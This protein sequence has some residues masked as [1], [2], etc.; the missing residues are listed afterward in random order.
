[1]AN[2]TTCVL[3]MEGVDVGGG[4]LEVG[5]EG[6]VTPVGPQGGL[7]TDE[8]GAAH[9]EAPALVGALGH[10]G[11]APFGVV[12][13]HP[14]VLGEGGDGLGQ[15]LGPGA[16]GHGVVDPETPE[17]ARSSRWTKSPNQSA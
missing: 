16:H 6:E 9:D 5:Q 15:G 1:M 10:L 11:P 17:R 7:G 3:T 12:D 2:S 8:A 13:L 14:G 4:P